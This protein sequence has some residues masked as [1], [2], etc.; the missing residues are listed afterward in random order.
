MKLMQLCRQ[1]VILVFAFYG[2]NIGQSN[3][4]IAKQLTLGEANPPCTINISNGNDVKTD[5]RT[6]IRTIQR[7]CRNGGTIHLT[8]TASEG[9]YPNLTVGQ[10]KGRGRLRIEGTGRGPNG[11]LLKG[12]TISGSGHITVS[13]LRFT[14][15]AVAVM[16]IGS[17]FDIDVTDVVFHVGQL[18]ILKTA[19][20]ITVGDEHS[21]TR[22]DVIFEYCH[23]SEGNPNGSRVC[24][25]IGGIGVTVQK[26][27]FRHCLDCDFLSGNGGNENLPNKFRGVTIRNNIFDE[28]KPGTQG[29]RGRPRTS[30]NYKFTVTC[31][32]K[33]G[34]ELIKCMGTCNHND[35]LIVQSGAKNWLISGNDFTGD[36]LYG[37]AMVGLIGECKKPFTN[38]PYINHV[39]VTD[40]IFDANGSTHSAAAILVQESGSDCDNDNKRPPKNV[41]ITSNCILTRVDPPGGPDTSYARSIQLETNRNATFTDCTKIPWIDGNTVGRVEQDNCVRGKWGAG[42][43]RVGGGLP[44]PPNDTCN[45]VPAPPNTC[46]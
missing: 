44:C 37:A 13:S 41:H 31:S 8:S 38:P 20:D 33:T 16:T 25:A 9:T 5:F 11:T 18:R 28:A 6:A 14:M 15:P 43:I 19:H 36:R 30:C 29:I 22:D 34:N 1:L 21:T 24:L 39:D 10:Y 17:S 3:N 27:T 32:G 45:N 42:N 26:T 35:Y 46:Q 23:G 12:L 7:E 40:N 4:S 2:L